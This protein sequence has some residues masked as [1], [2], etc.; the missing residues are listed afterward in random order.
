MHLNILRDK[1]QKEQLSP[2]MVNDF[3]DRVYPLL[4]KEDKR[5]FIMEF[6]TTNLGYEKYKSLRDEPSELIV[7]DEIPESKVHRKEDVL[8]KNQEV[9]KH[10]IAAQKASH[11]GSFENFKYN[12]K[13]LGLGWKVIYCLSS[14]LLF[15]LPLLSLCKQPDYFKSKKIADV[16]FDSTYESSEQLQ[17]GAKDFGRKIAKVEKQLDHQADPSSKVVSS[18]REYAS[19]KFQL[20]AA[21]GSSSRQKKSDGNGM[22]MRIFADNRSEVGSKNSEDCYYRLG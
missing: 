18:S 6:V 12:F 1:K 5:N 16:T 17:R 3:I 14:V 4:N 15:G 22:Q 13:N 8:M 19:P 20:Q 21:K 2:E 9:M 10:K 7:K 11:T